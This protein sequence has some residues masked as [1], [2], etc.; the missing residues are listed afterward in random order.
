MASSAAAHR[1]VDIQPA[2]DAVGAVKQRFRMGRRL[3]R[4]N[5]IEAACQMV[6]PRLVSDHVPDTDKRLHDQKPL[7]GGFR[8]G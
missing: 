6:D 4:Q 1:P 5:D 8:V 7:A 3:C 2:D